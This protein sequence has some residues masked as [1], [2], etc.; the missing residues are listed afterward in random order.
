MNEHRLPEP[1]G[2]HLDRTRP[3]S[4]TFEGVRVQGYA[5]DTLM[6]ALLSTGQHLVSRSFKYHRPRGPITMAG[7]DANTYVQNGT[8]PNALADRILLAEGLVANAQNVSGSLKGDRDRWIQHVSK[9]LP[10]GFYY[11]A[12]YKPKGIWGFWEKIIR[13]KAGLGKV[14]QSTPHSYH[15]KAYLF[16]DVTVIG[17]GPAGLSAAL[18]AA[19]AGCEVVLVDDQ[20]LLGGSL[21]SG[22]DSETGGGDKRV[23]E[24]ERLRKALA[25]QPKVTI[26]TDAR[27]TGWFSDNW[28]SIVCGRRLYKLRAGQVVLATGALEQPMVFRNNDLPGIMTGTAVQRC[29]RLWAVKPG[30]RAIVATCNAQGYAAALDLADAGTE[31]A[32]IVDLNP[33]PYDCPERR[34]AQA[35]GLRILPGHTVWEARADGSKNRLGSATLRGLNAAGEADGAEERIECDVLA[36]SIGFTPLAQLLCHAGGRLIYNEALAGLKVDHVPEG[37]FVAGAVNGAYDLDTVLAEGRHAGWAAAQAAGFKDRK[38]PGKPQKTAERVNHP[39][40]IFPHPEGKDF[41]DID[42]DQ[43]VADIHN[44]IADGFEHLELMKRYTTVGMGPSQG[45]TSALNAVRITARANGGSPAGYTVTTQR[46]PFVPESFGHLAGRAFDPERLTAMH[47]R[48]LELGAQMMPAGLWWRPGYYGPERERA[49]AIRAEAEAVRRNV[50]LIDVSTLGGIDVRGPDAR[51][52]MQ[53]LY[54][55]NYLKQPVGKSRYLLLCEETGTISDDGV[56]CCF[57]DDHFYVT[58]T[59]GG[60]DGVYRSMLRWNA[61]W[62]LDVDIANV[63]AAYAGVNIAGP[64]SRKVLETL[65]SDLDFSAE[66]FP[67][68]AVREGTLEGIPVRA[69]RVGFVGELGFELH[70]P[71]GQGEALWDLLMKAGA[72]QGIRPFGVEAQR[73]LRLEKGHIIIGQDTDGL[74][75]PDEASMAWAVGRKKP[76]FLGQRAILVREREGTDRKLTGFTL[77]MRA[78]LPEECNL[79]IRDGEIAGR[80]TSAS[81]AVGVEAII[82]LAYVH[83]KD[84]EPGTTFKIKLSNGSMVEATAAAIPFYD[85]ENKRQEL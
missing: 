68:L 65:E 21:N 30:R 40:P 50:G 7:L 49:E 35:R 41:V 38:S 79:V 31:V 47:E 11:K 59:T 37:A 82:G 45:R 2:L 74:T 78:P 70:C 14:D 26:L 81:Q 83:P 29:L 4:C 67:Y 44:A 76:F 3:L 48:H 54:T 42:E 20:P 51:E 58:A 22:R 34:A 55:F 46:P 52:F 84:A 80:V 53:R 8:E 1:Y 77:P 33:E 43:T 10:V 13:A 12:F 9:F 17:G 32:A 23:T 72:A 75:T 62:N 69:M 15:D 27:C 36:V 28:L 5:G 25:E 24:G 18:E 16:A 60:A 56:G 85:P 39:W 19:E 64:N 61:E 66:G 63:T 57:A 71:A 73:L 6:S